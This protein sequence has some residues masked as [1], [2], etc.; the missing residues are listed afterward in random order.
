MVD[1]HPGFARMQVRAF[2]Q[3]YIPEWANT[4][5]VSTLRFL[6]DGVVSRRACIHDYVIRLSKKKTKILEANMEHRKSITKQ[7]PLKRRASRPSIR[8]SITKHMLFLY[9]PCPSNLP[10]ISSLHRAN[11]PFKSSLQTFPSSF[12]CNSFAD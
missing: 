6:R 2:M 10:F 11:L 1:F 7:A 5:G 12:P 3:V 4:H 8:T 9:L